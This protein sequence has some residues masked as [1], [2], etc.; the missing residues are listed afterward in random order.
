M[1]VVV[2]VKLSSWCPF[3]LSYCCLF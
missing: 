3:C 2:R 1:M